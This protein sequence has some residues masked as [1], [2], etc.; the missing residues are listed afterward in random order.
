MN[1][2]RPDEL[3][4]SLANF[5]QEYLPAQRGMSLHTVHTY[6]DAI[7]LF[8]RFA[9]SHSGKPIEE[10]DLSVFTS[11]IISHFLSYLEHERNN[12]ISTRNSRLAALHTLARFQASEEPEHLADWQR[13]LALPFKRGARQVPVD[14][15]ESSEIEAFLS[16]IDRSSKLGRR[17][18]VLFSLMFNTGGRVQEILDLRHCDIRTEAPYQVR[19]QGK[20]KKIRLCPIWPHT[21]KL[22][23]ELQCTPPT[24]EDP[25]SVVFKNRNGDKLTRFG[26]RYLLK[27][28]V[29]AALTKQDSLV[30]KELHPHSLR[31]STAIALL[32]SGVDFASISQWL[33]HAS[34]NTTMNYARIDIDIKRQALAQVF[35]EVLPVPSAGHIARPEVN[36][37]G[38]LKRL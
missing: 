9:A 10:L 31:H 30:N 15:F 20:G 38:W 1:T 24:M 17:D 21:A 37:I 28:Y 26:V 3:G 23:K 33:G 16:Q 32:K 4:Q 7:V 2:R 11:E 18:F 35:P 34:L 22:L 29:S 5:F 8:L 6:R 36:L 13:I 25:G 14:Y 19:F 12:S 27:K